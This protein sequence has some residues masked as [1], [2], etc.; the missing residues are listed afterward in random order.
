M[1]FNVCISDIAEVIMGQS[2]KG[3][4]VNDTGEGYP[5]LNGPTEFTSRHPEPV[6]F[7][8]K[9]RKFSK[10][11]D[12][13]FCVRGSTTGKM[14]YAD[15]EYAIGRGIAAL[16]GKNGYPTPYVRAVIERNL[17]RLLSAATGSTFP[18][19][20]RELLLNFEVET[21]SPEESLSINELIVSLE[22]KIEL[23]R[24][25]NQTL[26][27]IAQ[28]LFKSWFVDF[29]PVKAKIAA[30]QAG[31]NAEQIERAAMAAISGKT[32]P[33]L[34]QL[35]PEQY[36]NLKTTAALFP[37][38]LVDSELGE[39]PK[40]W[41]EES[42]YEICDVIYGAPFKSKLFN[43]DG[44]GIPLVR[45]RDLKN[46]S[47]GVWTEEIHP[48]GYLIQ[49]GDLIIGMD[50]EFKP[51]IWGGNEAW[52]N[53]RVC[54]FKPKKPL[55][56]GMLRE[57]IKQDLAH[58]ESTATA[59]TVIHL[60]KGDIDNFTFINPG[61]ELLGV[62]DIT[63]NSLYKKIVANKLEN[64]NL[65]SQRD[66]LLPKLLSGDITTTLITQETTLP[67]TIKASD[68]IKTLKSEG[69]VRKI[70]KTKSVRHTPELMMEFIFNKAIL[71][72]KKN[73]LTYQSF[74]TKTVFEK[75]NSL[76]KQKLSLAVS[77][78][79]LIDRAGDGEAIAELFKDSSN[80]LS[81][82]LLGL[83]LGLSK[84]IEALF[85]KELVSIHAVAIL[86]ALVESDNSLYEDRLFERANSQL[87][88]LGY[89]TMTTKLF[90]KALYLL[91]FKCRLI[92]KTDNS[93]WYLKENIE[94]KS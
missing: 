73:T 54:C 32:E 45:I 61:L 36:Q 30:K 31:G 44:N 38:E 87:T 56:S 68:W 66:A 55:S 3:E 37:D 11:G 29:D 65:A 25:T 7:T 85:T 72:V 19:V 71:D 23:N 51:Y 57:F 6:Q 58:Y 13:L 16:R 49:N 2:P 53:Q 64:T 86:S 83:V 14:N 33:E 79:F 84:G 9:G 50:G 12:I 94:V 78:P 20:G 10:S 91:Q 60:G 81:A 4:E 70:K 93:S 89:Q 92:N 48:K 40:G 76:K 59:T 77:L 88:K 8:T 82:G 80:Y 47:P 35:T 39:I 74:E 15:R 75:L 62:F 43:T 34:D 90:D 67:E 17:D 21:V 41:V 26:E 63:I 46:E 22:D 1:T 24:Q 18:N 42:I 28:A 5:L 69:V 27:K 52:M